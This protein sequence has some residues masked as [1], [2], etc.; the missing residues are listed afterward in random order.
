MKLVKN[1]A[2]ENILQI[3]NGTQEKWY[4]GKA[5]Q[6]KNGTYE[7]MRKNGTQKKWYCKYK[8]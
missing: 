8:R 2:E 3:E 4:K 5:I 1:G 6:L 7:K